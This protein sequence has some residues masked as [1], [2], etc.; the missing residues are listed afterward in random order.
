MAHMWDGHLLECRDS[1]NDLTRSKI[2]GELLD[3]A[4]TI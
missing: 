2:T 4:E 1:V 3:N